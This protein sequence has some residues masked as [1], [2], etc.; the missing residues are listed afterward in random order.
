MRRLTI[1]AFLTAFIAIN[2]ADKAVFGLAAAP[3]M[4]DLRLNHA[5]FGAIGSSFFLLFSFSALL[6][7][8]LGDR[9][10]PNWLLAGMALVW[11]AA[12]LPA[13]GAVSVATLVGLRV[14]LGAGEGPA[15]PVALQV[16]YVDLPDSQRPRITG[17]ILAGAPLGTAAAALFCTWL[18]LR[19]GWHVAFVTLGVVSFAWAM[20]WLAVAP[21]LAPSASTPAA[22]EK[23]E[24]VLSMRALLTNR[25]MLGV[26]LASFAAYWASAVAVIWFPKF[27]ERGAGW[28]EATAGVLL[29]LAWGMQIP[30]CILGGW[31]AEALQRRTRVR[32]AAYRR[33]AILGV[34]LTGASFLGL[35]FVR[36]QSLAA[37]FV[38]LSLMAVVVVFV[39][40]GPIVAEIVPR[41][42]RGTALGALV[43]VYALAGFI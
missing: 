40:A 35:A 42:Q 19:Y 17:I 6:I 36:A 23:I 12:Q 2:F 1:V 25:T 28:S 33:L 26:M 13:A 30:I 31:T 15:F 32:G 18:M 8:W 39:V 10:N 14:M 20:L 38:I 43:A 34:A 9:L 21:R 37:T 27:L 3:I 41:A 29:A 16:A 5:Q 24:P 11:T 4:R 22:K 7:G